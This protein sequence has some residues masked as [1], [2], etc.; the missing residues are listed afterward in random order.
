MANF[1][2]HRCIVVQG[3]MSGNSLNFPFAAS[4]CGTKMVQ[5]FWC[6]SVP[7]KFHCVRAV[8]MQCKNIAKTY[9]KHL[10]IWLAP[11]SRSRS[12]GRIPSLPSDT[13]LSEDQSGYRTPEIPGCPKQGGFK[14]A[15]ATLHGPNLSTVTQHP[16]CTPCHTNSNELCHQMN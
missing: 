1:I 15:V 4:P 9:Q 8:C 13:K 16:F 6:V 3:W 12:I 5:V 7:L 11:W 2:V 14:A 10:C